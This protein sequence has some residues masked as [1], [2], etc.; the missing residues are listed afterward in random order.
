MI[1]PRTPATEVAT[2]IRH[3]VPGRA[4]P[5]WRAR[6]TLQRSD[7]HTHARR[8]STSAKLIT[9]TYTSSHHAL[10]WP[11]SLTVVIARS[12]IPGNCSPSS[13]NM[14]PLKLNCSIPQTAARCTRMLPD[15]RPVSST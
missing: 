13:T 5:R 4:S 6:S 9:T 15:T 14:M 3:E 1:A 7:N 8:S 2:T 11:L 12:T 10:W